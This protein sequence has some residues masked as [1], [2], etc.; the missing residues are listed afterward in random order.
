MNRLRGP[1]SAI[2]NRNYFQEYGATSPVLLNTDIPVTSD[3][4]AAIKGAEI[5]EEKQICAGKYGYD[6]C[7]GDTGG[8]LVMG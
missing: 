3:C 6:S 2:I 7:N 5:N 4:N 1:A 8:P